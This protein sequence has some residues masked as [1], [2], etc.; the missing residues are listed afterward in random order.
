MDIATLI[1]L[2]GGIAL[3][4]AAIAMGGDA[5]LFFSIP[6]LMIVLGGATAAT[7]IK[8]SL[9]HFINSIK[10]AINA[11]RFEIASPVELILTANEM[12]DIS[13]KKGVLALDGFETPDPFL[14]RGAQMLAD[15]YKPEL[16]HKALT[17][18]MEQSHERHMVGQK[19]FRAVGESAPAFGMIG[20]LI[21]LIQMLN[22]LNDPSGIGPAMAVALL[23]TLYG[24]LIANLV[25]LPIADKLDLRS[26]QE[27]ANQQLI[28]DIVASIQEGH[29]PRLM[30]EV[31]EAYLP[32]ADRTRLQD[33]AAQSANTPKG[34]EGSA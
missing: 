18:E 7:L 3:V 14:S 24:A 8:F 11:F 25:A 4:G 13:R 29:S 28:M 34:Q 30:V 33:T 23:T 6:S 26:Q 2:L 1:G 20:T 27:L 21:G 22:S 9:S 5:L 19:L 15:G 17:E 31:L 16:L 10:V 12:A 32:P